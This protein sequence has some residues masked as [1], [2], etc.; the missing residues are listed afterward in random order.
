MQ[1]GI[2]A[3]GIT[4]KELIDQYGSYADM[5]QQLFAQ[6]EKTFDYQVFDVRLGHFPH[7]ATECDAWVITG[8]ASN[9]D[10]ETDWMQQLKELI[11]EI[12]QA[13]KPMVG[14]CFGH[15]IIA[16][17][18]GGRVEAYSGGWG[19]G[20]HRYE[21]V[22]QPAF[23]APV[24]AQIALSAMHR[25]QVVEKPERATV[26]A[27]SSFCQFAGLLYGPKILTL[28]A[29]PEFNLAFESELLE[30]RDG[31]VIPATCAAEARESLQA[32]GART[33]SLQVAG[34]MAEVLER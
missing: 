33:D 14:I 13:G 30:L 16:E 5:F 7:S 6:A 20:L 17:A 10:E 25:Y 12:D 26:F 1:V 23:T 15:Q 34:W 27:Q 9:V 28:Q 4:P 29:H 22:G 18:F 11:V 21:I 19:A 8:S 2:L 31:D 24:P 32:S 3:T